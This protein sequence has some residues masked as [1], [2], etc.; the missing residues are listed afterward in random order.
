[1]SE[2]KNVVIVGA[3]FAGTSIAS[4]LSAKL[5]AAK[6]NLILISSRSY[7]ISLPAS[8]RLVVS[9][10]SKLEDTAF[11]PL[12]K[13]YKNGNGETKVGV[14]KSIEA[15]EGEKSGA[16]VLESGERVEYEILVLAT[17][18]KWNGPLNLPANEKDVLPHVNAWREKFANAKH[19][20][21]AG[22]G[23]VGIELAGE[24]KDEHPN[25]KVTIVQG[26]KQLLNST[27]S[28]ALRTGME[29]RVRARGI[30]VLFSEYIDEI[31]EEGSIGV[32]TRA[33]TQIP[34]ADLVI[35]A[36]GP[37]PNTSFI[38]SL[39]SSALSGSGYVKVRPTLQLVNYPSIFAA[40]DIIEWA[41]Q[42]QAAKTRGH[43]GVI[44]ANI[45][46]LLQGG[47][48]GNLKVY[49]GSPEM[50]LITNG[51]NGGMAYFPFFGGFTLGDWFARL[52]KSKG[53]MVGMFRSGL[54]Y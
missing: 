9:P 44:V 36:R 42:K 10:S 7:A 18:A 11:V 30:E 35:S 51:R 33:G 15:K 13:L 48:A 26:D 45:L 25:T 52:L 32:T 40:G 22:G 37:S 1:M 27:Y 3:G 16:V 28:N 39:D 24:L 17:G 53:L 2:K 23:A 54:G 21:L 14:V 50:I 8:A 41:E 34:T 12:D 4:A 5:D 20:V 49:G 29:Q 38:S 6:Y 43:A 46:S 47:E 31:P 19:V